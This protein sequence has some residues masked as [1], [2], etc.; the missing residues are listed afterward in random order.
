MPSLEPLAQRLATMF[1]NFAVPGDPR[2]ALSDVG[3]LYH[4]NFTFRDPIQS[5]RGRDAFV[6][7][8]L[9]LARKMAELSFDV[10]DVGAGERAVFLAWTMRAKPRVGPLL[11]IPGATHASVVEGLIVEHVDH[12]DLLGSFADVIPGAGRAYRRLVHALLA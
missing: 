10:H 4:P 5:F 3:V 9:E 1:R 8:N 11:V 7:M 6:T 12:W 2:E